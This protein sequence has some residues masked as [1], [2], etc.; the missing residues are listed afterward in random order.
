MIS[1]YIRGDIVNQ[2]NNNLEIKP[3]TSREL[4]EIENYDF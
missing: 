1:D 3:H 4:I 2:E